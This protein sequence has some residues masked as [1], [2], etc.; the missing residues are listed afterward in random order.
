[1]IEYI[2][3]WIYPENKKIIPIIYPEINLNFNKKHLISDKD[4]LNVKLKHTDNIIPAPARNMPN[5]DKFTLHML[6]KAQL[7]DIL[8][9]KLKKAYVNVKKD[10]YEPQHPV[11]KELLCKRTKILC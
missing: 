2:Y 11:L 4:L 8:A 6:S 3:S 7:D 5:L 9:V 10:V 1:M